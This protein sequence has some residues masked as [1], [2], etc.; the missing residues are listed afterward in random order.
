MMVSEQ[1]T[2]YSLRD[3]EAADLPAVL[4]LNRVAV[5][6]VNDIGHEQMQWFAEHAAYFRVASSRH[7]ILA[8]L[9]GLRPGTEY[10]SPNYRWFCDRYEDFGYIDRVAVSVNARRLGLATTLYRDFEASL[11]NRVPVLTCEVNIRPPND[12]SMHFH[13]RNGFVRVA[14]QVIDDGDKEVALRAKALHT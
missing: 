1:H 2:E 14:T 13:E 10:A 4:R 7:G 12:S 8:F 9:I 11:P 3:V 5:P 6:A